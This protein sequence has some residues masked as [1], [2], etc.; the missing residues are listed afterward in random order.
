[1]YPTSNARPFIFFS[2]SLPKSH[3]TLVDCRYVITITKT[4]PT[5]TTG[6]DNH[7][8]VDRDGTIVIIIIVIII[9]MTIIITVID[10][11]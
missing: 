2:L 10:N 11:H 6:D 5:T 1:M 7:D 8:D 4:V 3:E 9:V